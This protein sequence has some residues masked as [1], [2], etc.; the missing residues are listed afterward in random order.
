MT[1][2]LYVNASPR[3]EASVSTQ[4]AAIFLQ[5]LPDT[6]T[7]IRLDLFHSDLPEYTPEL[8]RA[9]QKFATGT[10]MTEE[11]ARQWQEVTDLV[12]QFTE[13]DHYLLAVPMWNFSV[14]YKLK[15]YIDLITHPGLTFTRDAGGIRGLASGDTTVIFAR[16][17]NY[18]PKNGQPDPYDFQSPYLNAWLELVGLGPVSEVLAQGTLAGPDAATQAVDNVRQQLE[19]L[20]KR[21][22]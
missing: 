17:G 18:S 14:P 1:D 19:S 5:A 11:E 2:L 16:G 21:L 15:Q 20:A 13:V 6:V 22:G 9:K 12:N 3:G 7:V 8:A 4:S 10:E